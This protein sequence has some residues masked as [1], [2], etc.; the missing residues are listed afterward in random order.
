MTNAENT[1]NHNSED[2]NKHASVACPQAP[3]VQTPEPQPV[4]EADISQ[5]F[6]AKQTDRETQLQSCDSENGCVLVMALLRSIEPIGSDVKAC[7]QTFAKVVAEMQRL[8]TDDRVLTY[9]SRQC[10]ELSEKHYERE[11]LTPIFLALIGILDRI[12]EQITN[13]EGFCKTAGNSNTPAVLA[14]R[15]LLESRVADR[16]EIEN[17]LANYAVEPF[18]SP[19]D[20]FDPT[21]QKYIG[22]QPCADTA[23]QGCIAQRLLPGY[24][25]LGKVLKEER[26]DIFIS[27]KNVTPSHKGERDVW[28]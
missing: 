28:I 5:A 27:E 18:Q 11:V 4:S 22:K 14:I 24:R 16:V 17:L 6:M 23:L 10:R 7:L 15:Y 1:H 2:A 25:R 20:K 26:V 3:S 12:C 19:D 9:L 13:L 8:K 21:C